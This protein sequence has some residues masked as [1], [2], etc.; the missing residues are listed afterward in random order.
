MKE[1]VYDRLVDHLESEG[2][3]TEADADF[4]ESN[5]SDLVYCI[6]ASTLSDFR[7]KTGR[8][9][10]LTREKEII[11]TYNETGGRE[12]FVVLDRISVTE[13]RFV[14]IVEGK[15][16]STREARKQC[17]LAMKDCWDNID[18]MKKGKNDDVCVLYGFVTTGEDWSM[19]RYD[20]STFVMTHKFMAVF[21]TMGEAKE[22][23]LEKYSIVV[24]CICYA[25]GDG[26]IMRKDM[27]VG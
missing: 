9:L 3:P 22:M 8:N 24:D 11:S 18:V 10:R 23:W 20:G 21:E 16:G 26:G 17:L 19:I 27:V 2:Y 1:K 25:L 4:S 5:I 13:K 12:E 7:R 6:L 14:L 15:R